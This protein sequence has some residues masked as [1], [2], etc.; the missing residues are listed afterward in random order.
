MTEA[1]TFLTSLFDALLNYA[2]AAVSDDDVGE[3]SDR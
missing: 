2:T 1:S 3:T